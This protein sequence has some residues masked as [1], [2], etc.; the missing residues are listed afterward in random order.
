MRRRHPDNYGNGAVLIA[1]IVVLA[2]FAGLL[3]GAR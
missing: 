2:A 3:A 1:I